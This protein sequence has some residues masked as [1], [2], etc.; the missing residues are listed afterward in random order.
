MEAVR[1]EA[2]RTRQFFEEEVKEYIAAQKSKAGDKALRHAVQALVWA[3]ALDESLQQTFTSY[4]QFRASSQHGK[5][6]RALGV[7]RNSGV[8]QLANVLQ[9]TSGFAFPAAFPAR[10]VDI[11]WKS[12]DKLPPADPDHPR[13]DK[14]VQMYRETLEHKSVIDTLRDLASFFA[15]IFD[16]LAHRAA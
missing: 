6:L 9:T 1:M 16:E 10:F 5:V 7:V 8:H 3:R 2:E 14:L 4:M 15:A 12:I 13:S 11:V